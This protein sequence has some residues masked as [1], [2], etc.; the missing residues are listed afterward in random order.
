[1]LKLCLLFQPYRI[2]DLH[3]NYIFCKESSQNHHTKL[4]FKRLS[5][6]KKKVGDLEAREG[7]VN[8]QNEADFVASRNLAAEVSHY[9]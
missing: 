1:M 3:K 4:N 6:F 5:R 7:E 8:Q 2:S 9:P